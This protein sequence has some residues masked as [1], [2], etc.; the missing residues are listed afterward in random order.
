MLSYRFLLVTDILELE[1]VEDSAKCS[2]IQGV[3]DTYGVISDTIDIMTKK[4]EE[5]TIGYETALKSYVNNVSEVEDEIM[6][7]CKFI[8]IP[9]TG[10]EDF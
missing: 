1:D 5:E 9:S 10:E 8:L 3:V 2:Q 6:K 7:N 4:F